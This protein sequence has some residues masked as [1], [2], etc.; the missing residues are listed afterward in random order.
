[1][2]LLVFKRLSLA[3][4]AVLLIAT[5]AVPAVVGAQ[6][7]EGQTRGEQAR[8]AAEERR[9]SVEEAREAR[10]AEIQERVQER[11]AQVQADVCER[12]QDQLNQVLPRLATQ[13]TRLAA[14]MDTIYERVQGFYESGQLTVPNY[15]ELDEAVAASQAEAQAAVELVTT[16]EFELDCDNPSLGDQM[17]TFRE[18]VAEAREAL[19]QYR[20]DLV[21]LISSLRAAAA[22]QAEGTETEADEDET[23]DENDVDGVEE[24]EEDA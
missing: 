8:A 18:S 13:S 12:R 7:G 23:G 2:N 3:T 5:L 6:Q 15:D 17:F 1:M 19:K 16:Y 11:R 20:T 24:E 22:E 10:S 9:R 21:T 4:I 14:N